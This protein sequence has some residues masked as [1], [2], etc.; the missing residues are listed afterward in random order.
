MAADRTCV[1]RY[2]KIKLL[3]YKTEIICIKRLEIVKSLQMKLGGKPI[4]FHS[5]FTP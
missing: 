2:V 5:V 3:F 1:Q 4:Y